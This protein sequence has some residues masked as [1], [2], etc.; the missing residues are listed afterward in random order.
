VAEIEVVRKRR[1]SMVYWIVGAV[2]L[3]LLAWWLTRPSNTVISRSSGS[4]GLPYGNAAA[5]NAAVFV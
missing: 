2:I 3:L 4:S 5:T 1:A